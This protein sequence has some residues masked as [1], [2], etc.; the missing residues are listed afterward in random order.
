MPRNRTERKL[1]TNSKDFLQKLL[2]YIHQ[3]LLYEYIKMFVF[4]NGEFFSTK[5]LFTTFCY[6]EN[7]ELNESMIFFFM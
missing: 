3:W 2:V 7:K 5:I 1:L 4:W 6:L